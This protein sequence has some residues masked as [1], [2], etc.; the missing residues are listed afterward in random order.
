MVKDRTFVSVSEGHFIDPEM[1]NWT[2]IQSLNQASTMLREVNNRM[3]NISS[4]MITTLLGIASA[5]FLGRKEWIL[6]VAMLIIL[7]IWAIIKIKRHLKQRRVLWIWKER[8]DKRCKE[9]GIKTPKTND[10][11]K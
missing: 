3:S 11:K 4:I 1:D 2:S 5:Y 8:I 7:E 6:M 9:L 10:G